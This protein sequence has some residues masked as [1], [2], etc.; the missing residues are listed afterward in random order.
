MIIVMSVRYY[1]SANASNQVNTVIGSITNIV[2]SADSLSQ[3]SG[4]FDT[5]AATAVSIANLTPLVPSGSLTTPWGTDFT[6]T[7]VAASTYTINMLQTPANVCPLVKSKL[8]ANNHFT[9]AT[10]CAAAAPTDL[11]IVYKANP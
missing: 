3:A 4:R 6:I 8:T 11:A 2:A 9:I 10:A 7:G 1:Q 5:P